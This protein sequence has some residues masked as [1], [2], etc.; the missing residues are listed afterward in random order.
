MRVSAVVLC[1]G[2]AGDARGNS[3]GLDGNSRP[4][5]IGGAESR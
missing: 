4:L 2:D 1:G 3:S 5:R